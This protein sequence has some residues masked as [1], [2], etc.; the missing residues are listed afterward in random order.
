MSRSAHKTI[1]GVFGGKFASTM[2]KKSIN[3]K[4]VKKPITELVTKFGGNPVWLTEPQWPISKETGKP[5]RFICQIELS[6]DIF[7]KRVCKMAYIFMTDDEEYVDGTWE[8]EGGENAVILQPGN[9]DIHT[10]A[11]NKDPT[12]YKMEKKFLNKKLV[13]VSC[14][15]EVELASGK[16]PEFVPEA[17][18]ASWDED[19][20]ETYANALDGNKIGGT[21]IFLQADEFPG[22]GSWQLIL[23]LDSTKVPFSINFGDSGIGYAFISKEENIGKFLWQCS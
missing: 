4:Q 5:M 17:E 15:F 7:G 23:E 20:C 22:T 16:D 19:K 3:F 13:P 2:N 1:K 10:E 8:P 6:E 12:L 21:P 18:R 9:S 11:L 14:E